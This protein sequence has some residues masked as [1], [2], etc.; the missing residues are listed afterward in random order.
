MSSPFKMII[1]PITGN[2]H[3]IHSNIGQK[4]LNNYIAYGGGINPHTGKEWSSYSCAKLD[5]TICNQQP[6]NRC[7][8][9]NKT[10]TTSAYCRK[11]QN[12]SRKRAQA[13]WTILKEQSKQ[14]SL[15]KTQINSK[16]IKQSIPHSGLGK[17]LPGVSTQIIDE[18]KKSVKGNVYKHNENTHKLNDSEIANFVD[19]LFSAKT[20]NLYEYYDGLQIKINAGPIL[21]LGGADPESWNDFLAKFLNSHLAEFSNLK[22]F[23]HSTRFY[24]EFGYDF[25]VNAPN[26][27]KQLTIDYMDELPSSFTKNIKK[28]TLL[29]HGTCTES[30]YDQEHPNVTELTIKSGLHLLD[31]D[32]EELNIELLKETLKLFPNLKVIH[33]EKNS[34][35][36]DMSS[37]SLIEF[38][39]FFIDNGIKIN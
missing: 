2:K 7:S 33:I 14:Q 39:Q 12:S 38:K 37:E 15:K 5:E 13:N 10:D 34:Y 31:E 36:D 8:W 11:S 18:F 20:L 17:V 23:E 16:K 21:Y 9:K 27:L 30:E 26:S 4:T 3:P 35:D 6:N 22:S 24:C 32:E 19:D 1:N 29:R 25:L 28:I